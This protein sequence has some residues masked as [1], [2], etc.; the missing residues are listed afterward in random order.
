MPLLLAGVPESK[1][2][3]G[4]WV[5]VYLALENTTVAFFVV[6]STSSFALATSTRWLMPSILAWNSSH[7]V[8]ILANMSLE[9]L[10][11]WLRAPTTWTMVSSRRRSVGTMG[12]L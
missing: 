6:L 9:T 7:L 11:S 2:H 4:K 1:S 5:K 3:G 12:M 10:V 8:P